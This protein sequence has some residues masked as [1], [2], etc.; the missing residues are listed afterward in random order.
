MN[1]KHVNISRLK[2]LSFL[3]VL[4]FS[5]QFI[6][7][8]E[9]IPFY[10]NADYDPEIKSPQE[11][12]GFSIGEKPIRYHRAVSYLKIL[13][14]LSPRVNIFMT[15]KTHEGRALFHLVISSEEN[16]RNLLTIK[17]KIADLSDSRKLKSTSAAS[18]IA[19]ETPAIAWLMYSIHGDELSGLDAGVY[20]AYHLA[21]ANDE[22]TKSVLENVVIGLD[23]SENPDGRE[24]YLAQLQQWNSNVIS[25]DG[26]SIQHSS[27]WPYGRGNHY[28]FDLNR[29]WFIMSQ[30]ET[31]SR[32]EAI[33]DWHPQLVVDAHEMGSYDTYLFNPPREPIN[34]YLSK[35]VKSWWKTYTADQAGA[36][37]KYGWSY[38]TREWLEEWYPGY[39]SS[40]P[41]YH[42]AVSILYEQASTSGT[43]LK[44]HDGTLSTFYTAVHHQFVSS[45]TNVQTLARNREKILND[46]YRIRK[47]AVSLANDN[48][49]RAYIIEPGSNISRVN[50]LLSRLQKQGIEIH[51]ANESFNV[52]KLKTYGNPAAVSKKFAS[53]TYIIRLDQPLRYLINVLFDYDQRMK[54][55]FLEEERRNLSQGKGTRLYEVSSWSLLPAYHVDAYVSGDIPTVSM[56]LVTDFHRAKGTVINHNPAYGY[57]L[58]MRD[59]ASIHALMDLF[60]REINIRVAKKPFKIDNREYKRG[61]LLIRNVEND[62]DF[63]RVVK[64]IAE[65]KGVNFIGVNTAL[66]QTGSDLGAGQFQLLA[67]PKIALLSGSGLSTTSFGALWYMLDFELQR[68]FSI[69]DYSRFSRVDLRK[70]NVLILPSTWGSHNNYKKIIGKKDLD[71][72]KKWV[73]NGGTL[74]AMGSSAAYLADSTSGMSKT[75]LRRQVVKK[76]KDY[77]KALKWEKESRKVVIDSVS[78]W[79]NRKSKAVKKD[80]KKSN[81]ISPEELVA[82]DKQ[83]ILFMPRG[84]I[85]KVDLDPEH[86][87]SFGLE[88]WVPAIYYSGYAYM[89]K[90]PVQVAGRFANGQDL[91]ISGLLWPEGRDRWQNTAYVTRE[92]IGNGQ[93]ILFAG[94]PVFRSYFYGTGRILLNGIL[95]G[96][97][98]GA[99]KGIDF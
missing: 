24:R 49:K 9:Q 67:A 27:V 54:T 32:V 12:F 90:G 52:R 69:I 71:K 86:W 56:S 15:G 66:S 92:K 83:Q 5:F 47:D 70:Y 89:A 6:L 94:D 78:I 31:R 16:M 76:L 85:L 97:G 91:R 2:R 10:E 48:G 51:K 20:M 4:L 59:D 34:P 17:N 58:D 46:Y 73:E 98:M 33:V 60:E 61:T 93:I 88:K 39:G 13:S 28:L 68:P 36:F 26:Q 64:E 23:I 63:H 18:V 7:G 29:D 41:S 50:R 25:T 8:Q 79:E 74:I 87:L 99:N 21:A 80:E 37:D 53:G 82:L 11:Y 45:F 42:G 19:R 72:I 77:E 62:A 84:A 30:P 22:K 14:D 35:V 3:L 43:P 40:W 75:R 44:R 38:Y 55:K 65:N 1:R 81:S 96:P 95:L 57:L